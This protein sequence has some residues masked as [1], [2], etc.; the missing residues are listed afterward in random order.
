[1]ENEKT[2]TVAVFRFG[3]ISEFVS[4]SGISRSTIMKWILAYKK[5]GYQI[6]ALY[7]KIRADKGKCKVLDPALRL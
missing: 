3:I 5:G 7:P 6:E 4:R 2:K 1:M